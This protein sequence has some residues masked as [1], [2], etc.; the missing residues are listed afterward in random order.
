MVLEACIVVVVSQVFET[1]LDMDSSM[2]FGS[3]WDHKRKKI[4]N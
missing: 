1:P 4:L 3:H 2:Y